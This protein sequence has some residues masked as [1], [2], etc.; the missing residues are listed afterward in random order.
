M[1]S[2]LLLFQFRK[3]MFKLSL[4]NL[5]TWKGDR[6]RAKKYIFHFKRF[7]GRL[8][9]N[10]VDLGIFFKIVSSHFWSH[11]NKML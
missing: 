1:F 3:R 8:G 9:L 10:K 4:P 11:E 5:R 2:S 7:K 6:N